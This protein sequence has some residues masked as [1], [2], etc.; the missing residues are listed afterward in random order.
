MRGIGVV[1]HRNIVTV[2]ITVLLMLAWGSCFIAIKTGLAYFP[3]LF[4][5]A[6]RALGAGAVLLALAFL[7]KDPWPQGWKVWLGIISLAVF[8]TAIAFAGMFLSVGTVGAGIAAVLSNTQPL[9]VAVPAFFLFGE[10]LGPY[11]IV[12]LF[13]GLL[14]TSLVVGTTQSFFFSNGWSREASMAGVLWALISAAGISVGTLVA[15]GLSEEKGLI[16]IA[17]WQF[18]LGGVPLIARSS[19]QES[20]ASV[21][22]TG[23]SL[24]ALPLHNCRG[25]RRCLPHL[26]LSG[27]TGRSNPGGL[28][29]VPGS[30]IWPYPGRHSGRGIAPGRRGSW[31]SLDCCRYRDRNFKREASSIAK[32]FEHSQDIKN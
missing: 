13:V 20:L 22:L 7:L 6:L 14:G 21:N 9:I 11:R 26:V 15:K 25:D 32:S 29:H 1:R 28:L 30:R 24:R 5:A 27:A 8:N 3:P 31:D 12:G 16:Q 18:V 23:T 19:Y 10:S 2:S 4:F 17:A